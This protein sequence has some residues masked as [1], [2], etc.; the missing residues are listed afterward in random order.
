[1]SI[2]G[3]LISKYEDITKKTQE[4]DKKIDDTV[5]VKDN[6]NLNRDKEVTLPGEK[7]EEDK[8]DKE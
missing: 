2:F 5:T 6:P 8:K 1:M 7:P 3:D 4:C